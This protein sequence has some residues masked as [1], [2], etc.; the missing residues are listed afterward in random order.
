MMNQT[1]WRTVG[2][3]AGG[4]FVALLL[5]L[6]MNTL[7]SGGKG[8]QGAAT[9]GQIVDLIRVQEDPILQTKRRVRPKKPPPPKDPPPPPIL[10]VS[11]EEK[12]QKNPMRID[13]PKI[14]VSGA[15]GGGPF[16]G[17]WDPGDPA[18]EGEAI[19]I[20]RIDPQYPREALMD[21]T[22]GYVKFEVLIGTDGSVLDVKVTEAAPGRIFVRNAVRAVRRWKFKPRVVD[23]V[24]VERW[25]K[26]SI[27]FEL[28]S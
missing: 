25:A 23:G 9:A 21:G 1:R 16:I 3:I 12:P 20:V 19:P 28:D 4:V 24:P 17:T 6:F 15:A 2:S 5:F 26:T 27:V 18:A 13:L 22:E 14:D 11:N 7:I 10:K 8:Q